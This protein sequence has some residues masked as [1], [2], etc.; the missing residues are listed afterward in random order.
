MKDK[1]KALIVKALI[2]IYAIGLII[3]AIL[4]ICFTH[5]PIS[6]TFCAIIIT[7]LISLYSIF[8]KK[9]NKFLGISIKKMDDKALEFYYSKL[10]GSLPVIFTGSIIGISVLWTSPRSVYVTSFILKFQIGL[11]MLLIGYVCCWLYIT[12]INDFKNEFKNRHKK[13]K[14]EKIIE[15]IR[16]YDRN[17]NDSFFQTKKGRKIAKK[18]QETNKIMEGK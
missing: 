18:I 16:R 5:S 9:G 2:V 14:T 8:I 4:F 3:L 15:V 11:I 17:P 7:V 6:V 10:L 1:T 13:T 12:T